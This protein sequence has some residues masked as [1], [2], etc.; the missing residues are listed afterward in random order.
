MNDREHETLIGITLIIIAIAMWF[1]TGCGSVVATSEDSG[2]SDNPDSSMA[3][4]NNNS[5]D[6]NIPEVNIHDQEINAEKLIA[7]IWTGSGIGNFYRLEFYLENN[8]NKTFQGY[9]LVNGVQTGNNGKWDY[10][11]D[12]NV[13]EI[14]TNDS[15][16]F[17]VTCQIINNEIKIPGYL[18]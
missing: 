12:L 18:K 3:E 5:P 17:K 4:I 9:S 16:Y 13:L 10:V 8:Y 2:V 11:P 15:Q 14:F 6:T 7:G 1:V